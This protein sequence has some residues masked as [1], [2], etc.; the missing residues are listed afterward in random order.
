MCSGTTPARMNLM[1]WSEC[2][3]VSHRTGVDIYCISQSFVA[4]ILGYMCHGSACPAPFP[5]TAHALTWSHLSLITNTCNHLP[6]PFISSL[7]SVTQQLVSRLHS[8][9]HWS[10][11]AYLP[12]HPRS[13]HRL[14]KRKFTYCETAH[15]ASRAF[16]VIYPMLEALPELY[17]I[18]HLLLASASLSPW[19]V[20]DRRPALQNTLWGSPPTSSPLSGGISHSL[21]TPESSA[22]SRQGQRSTTPPFSIYSGSGPVPINPWISQTP[23]DCLGEKVST[24]VWEVTG[25]ESKPTHECYRWPRPAHLHLRWSRPARLCLCWLRPVPR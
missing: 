8:S 22:G 4:Y 21:S 1:F 20:C 7:T 18:N 6:P 24:G 2:V 5:I 19:P 25:P 12:V 11:S 16:S 23:R 13:C 10:M 14:R 9:E 15:P 17:W 3:A